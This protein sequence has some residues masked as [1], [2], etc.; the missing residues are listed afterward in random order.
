MIKRSDYTSEMW[1]KKREIDLAF[2][3]LF[4]KQDFRSFIVSKVGYCP[5]DLNFDTGFEDDGSLWIFCCQKHYGFDS[6][7][8]KGQ[9]FSDLGDYEIEW[10]KESDGEKYWPLMNKYVNEHNPELS[11]KLCELNCSVYW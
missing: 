5:H 2:N 1:A 9:E 8:N 7:S 3:A 11:D 4:L 10:L 6:S